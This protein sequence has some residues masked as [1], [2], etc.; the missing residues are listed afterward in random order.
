MTPNQVLKFQNEIINQVQNTKIPGIII[1]KK[2]TWLDHI[3]YTD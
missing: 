3:T 1:D 2:L